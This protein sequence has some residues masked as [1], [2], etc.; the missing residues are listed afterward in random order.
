M[1]ALTLDEID[2]LLSE[3]RSRGEIKPVLSRF[4]S[5]GDL[6]INL[7]ETFPGKKAASLR[8]SVTVNLKTNFQGENSPAW[9]IMLVGKSVEDGGD[10]QAVVLVN[11][12]VYNAQKSADADEV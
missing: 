4:F 11:M 10:G 6:A 7:S 12:D 9:K 3:T 1:S 2:V 8:N 5:S